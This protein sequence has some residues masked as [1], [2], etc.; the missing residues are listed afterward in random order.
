MTL[1][2]YQAFQWDQVGLGSDSEDEANFGRAPMVVPLDIAPY[3]DIV[4]KVQPRTKET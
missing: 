4:S 1:N 3:P 2:G